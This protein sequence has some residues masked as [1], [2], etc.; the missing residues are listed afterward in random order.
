MH[1]AVPDKQARTVLSCE[2]QGL[3]RT[4]I[5]MDAGGPD[6]AGAETVDIFVLSP[7]CN[8][9]SR[10]RHGR[11]AS[12]I[13]GGAASAAHATAFVL[14]TKA[15]VVVIANVDEPDVTAS[16]ATILASARAYFSG[17]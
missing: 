12:I 17:S 15:K 8:A 9:F 10:R 3:A 2:A 16:I 1:A 4:H 13:A 14:Q 7:E 6:A 11:N 5:Y